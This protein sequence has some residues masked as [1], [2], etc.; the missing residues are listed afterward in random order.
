ML[1]RI[2]LAA[3]LIL[4][5]SSSP[6]AT[7]DAAVTPMDALADVTHEAHDAGV[8]APRFARS[9]D[10]CPDGGA[11]PYP[12]VPESSFKTPLPDLTL[13]TSDAPLRLGRYYTPCAAEPRLL[14]VRLMAAWSGPSRCCSSRKC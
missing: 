2:P 9:T 6:T 14:V 12:E 11:L 5:C 3:L 7:P 10:R 13:P 4:G 8:D 1:R